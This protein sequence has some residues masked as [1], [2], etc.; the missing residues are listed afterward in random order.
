MLD[1]ET[2]Y[3]IS[4]SALPKVGSKTILTLYE[5][6][7]SIKAAW[8]ASENKIYSCFPPGSD[9]AKAFVE[10]RKKKGALKYHWMD[11]IKNHDIKVIKIVDNEYPEVLN[12]IESPPILLYCRGDAS[13][14]DQRGF[15]IVGT[16]NPSEEAGK[17]AE[18][19][20]ALVANSGEVHI[21]GLAKGIDA[22]GHLG[23]LK[24][25]GKSVAV[26]GSGVLNIYPAENEPIAEKILESGGLLISERPP[27]SKVTSFQLK[28]RNRLIAA[29][30]KVVI[31]VE[32]SENS[33][34][35]IAARHAKYLG[36][37]IYVLGPI[38][39]TNPLQQGL[40]RILKR[41]GAKEYTIDQLMTEIS[42]TDSIKM[43]DKPNN[44]SINTSD[45]TLYDAD[46][47]SLVDILMFALAKNDKVFES[48]GEY[49]N[50][51][52]IHKIFYRVCEKLNLN[53]TRG[54]Y[55]RGCYIYNDNVNKQYLS[56]FFSKEPERTELYNIISKEMDQVISDE[57]ILSTKTDIFLDL[58]YRRY[59]PNEFKNIYINNHRLLQALRSIDKKRMK[60]NGTL[61]EWIHDSDDKEYLI[62]YL[63]KVLDD[64][65][66]FEELSSYIDDIERVTKD[67]IINSEELV[68]SNLIKRIEDYYY[69]GVW[70]LIASA[71]LI[72]T[73]K[74]PRADEAITRSNNSLNKVHELINSS[75]N[76]LSQLP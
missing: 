47:N 15:S 55:L 8:E 74:G 37:G 46:E 32:A 11:E 73:V 33:G 27:N 40:Q 7:N 41:G 61:S 18:E 35:L 26:L 43:V 22:R 36:N 20:G 54:W 68:N 42:S 56:T 21:S 10:G 19:L 34:S 1:E 30:S 31:V 38:D 17:S 70:S 71:I 64:A 4:A 25:N 72:R 63:N 14:L 28:H 49:L 45:L 58:L 5:E 66:Q 67:I 50:K 52:K 6:F 69:N 3:W 16:R 75:Q 57:K 24:E 39:S 62:E 53:L 44:T 12:R 51:L 48:K 59:A 9:F 65:R 76:L 29:L 13:L 23:A 60:N 2:L